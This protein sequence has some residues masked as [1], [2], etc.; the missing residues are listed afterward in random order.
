R[1]AVTMDLKAAGN[2][3]FVLGYTRR[4][5]GGSL[6]AEVNGQAGGIVPRVDLQRGPGLV[7]ALHRAMRLGLI[8]SCHDLSEGGLAVALAEMALASGLGAAVSLDRVPCDMDAVDP[9]VLLFSESPTRFVLEVAPEDCGRVEQ[10]LGDCPLGRLGEV[11]R[12][13]DAPGSPPRL[14]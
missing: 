5:L 2:V 4:E 14:S 6:W 13:G 11:G 9:F 8:P 7:R 10:I 1:A 12:R 3:L